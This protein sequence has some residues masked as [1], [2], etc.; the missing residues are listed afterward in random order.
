MN[1]ILFS[2]GLCL[3]SGA[4]SAADLLPLLSVDAGKSTGQ[5]YSVSVQILAIVTLLTLLPAMLMV[6]TSFTRVVVVLSILRQAIGMNQ[7]PSNQILVGLSIFLTLYIMSPIFSNINDNAVQPYLANKISM[8][9]AVEKAITPIKKFMLEQT[10]ESD[11][12]LFQEMANKKESEDVSMM[13]LLPS[14]VISELK[15]AFQIGFLIFIPF[16]II[17][18][19]VSSVL[20][21][22][23]M[24]MLSPLIISLPFKLML[25]ILVDGWSLII[26]TLASSYG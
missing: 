11:L 22:M 6:M 8:E 24:M 4:A 25:F 26:G 7:T 2:V 21:S 5:T 14:F 13:I 16:L 20:M 1:K 17:D 15:T 3:L 19:V 10:R 18:L 23:G 12:S 9:S